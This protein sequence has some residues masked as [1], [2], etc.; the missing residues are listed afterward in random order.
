MSA[1]TI[2]VT[3]AAAPV[4]IIFQIFAIIINPQ[5]VQSING[6]NSIF[7][8]A[9]SAKKTIKDL[10]DKLYSKVNEFSEKN[11]I[12]GRL[13]SMPLSILDV[14]LDT[15][16]LPLQLIESVYMAAMNLF[17]AAFFRGNKLKNALIH[18]ESALRSARAI[19]VT[20]AVA[21]VKIIFQIFAII[22]N[23]QKV[24]SINNGNPT[25]KKDQN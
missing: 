1:T 17:K 9:R 23:P 6:N 10:Q 22:I 13:C 12:L 4:K 16:A 21:P 20:I 8:E 7:E 3:I 2:P 14:T 11:K 24:Q 25:F 19:P 15:F 18:T 5:K